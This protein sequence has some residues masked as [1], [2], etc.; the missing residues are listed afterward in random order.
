M[1]ISIT[2][3]ESKRF[4]EVINKVIGAEMCDDDPKKINEV[5]NEMIDCA[6]DFFKVEEACMLE[7]KYS[8]Y[9]QH[10]EEHLDFILKAL[11]YYDRIAGGDYQMLS[12]IQEYLKQWIANHTLGAKKNIENIC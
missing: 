8:D 4:F 7:F 3:D 2:D 10:K 11:C 1:D 6:W 5:L 12:E 9:M